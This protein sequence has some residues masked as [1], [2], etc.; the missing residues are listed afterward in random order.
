[1]GGYSSVQFMEDFGLLDQLLLC[2]LDP[3][4]SSKETI[5][6]PDFKKEEDFYKA[7]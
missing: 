4:D 7:M 2:P 6:L 3:S 1:M 5:L